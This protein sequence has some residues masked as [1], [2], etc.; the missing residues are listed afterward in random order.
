MRK[1]IYTPAIILTAA[2]ML[3]NVNSFCQ[4]KIEIV[5]DKA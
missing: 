5:V 2:F 4:T 1:R 3:N